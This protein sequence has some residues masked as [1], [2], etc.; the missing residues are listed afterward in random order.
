MRVL[1]DALQAAE[2]QV[3]REH[4]RRAARQLDR[5]SARR[6]A[7]IG[8]LRAR[9]NARVL[10]DERRRGILQMEQSLTERPELRQRR[11]G[12][13]QHDAVARERRFVDAH[14]GRL[15]HRLELFAHRVIRTRDRAAPRDCS[16]RADV[17]VSATPQARDPARDEPARM[18]AFERERVD[19]IG[20]TR[21]L[22]RLALAIEAAQHGVRELAR[23]DA[24]TALRQLHRLRDRRV[25][26]HALHVQQL[27]GAESKQVE[28]VGIETHDAA[29]HARVEKRVE[30]RATAQ[31]PVHELAHPTAI[32]RIEPR[33]A[34]IERRI[35]Q[36]AAAKI[37]A[38]LRRRVTRVGHAAVRRRDSAAT[39]STAG[40][41][42]S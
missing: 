10:R 12:A 35:E 34:A 26:R 11:H 41:R 25:R 18:R 17:R 42:R 21:Q 33:G 23:A 9:R 7:E 2:R 29:A 32:A 31:H 13:R 16:P 20:E 28:Q 15:E 27:R 6:G 8:D 22:E 37:G 4:D 19:R 24:V 36:L 40:K 5:L 1:D 39:T 38:D 3:A 14:A 30:P